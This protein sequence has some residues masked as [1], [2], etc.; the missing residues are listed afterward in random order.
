M[1]YSCIPEFSDSTRILNI[2]H[3]CIIL[4]YSICHTGFLLNLGHYQ[5]CNLGEFVVCLAHTGSNWKPRILFSMVYYSQEKLSKLWHGNSCF[6][7]PKSLWGLHFPYFVLVQYIVVQK[8][9]KTIPR[10]INT[11]FRFLF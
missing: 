3:S 6:A 7:F 2:F 9:V 1:L 10:R 11:F 4:L 5:H 8:L